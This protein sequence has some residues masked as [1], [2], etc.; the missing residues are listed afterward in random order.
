LLAETQTTN[1]QVMC[2][3]EQQTCTLRLSYDQYV[4]SQLNAALLLINRSVKETKMTPD[5][6]EIVD[7]VCSHR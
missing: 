3:A 2:L 4:F 6:Q 7:A 1:G 5:F